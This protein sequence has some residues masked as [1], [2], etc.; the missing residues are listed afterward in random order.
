MQAT[1]AAKMTVGLAEV[2][3]PEAIVIGL[4]NRT[5]QGVVAEL[6]Q[7]L[8]GLGDITAY[9]A[10]AVIESILAREKV[11]STAMYDGVAFPHCRSAFTRRFVGV[12]GIEPDGIPFD[13][14]R[15]GLVHGVFLFLAPLERRQE[16]YEVLGRIA[17]IGRDKS[18]GAQ[19][20]GCRTPGAA[21]HFLQMQ[22]Q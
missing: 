13:A 4:K 10:G 7:H 2:F 12:L 20:R 15:G 16:L 9:E 3:R 19:L 18:R 8:V 1:S 5:K 6:I 14:L 22:D 11:G 17:A 21:H